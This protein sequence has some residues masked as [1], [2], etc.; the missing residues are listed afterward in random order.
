MNFKLCLVHQVQLQRWQRKTDTYRTW[1]YTEKS[2]LSLFRTSKVSFYPPSRQATEPA[3]KPLEMI[4]LKDGLPFCP[5]SSDRS[6]TQEGC[7]SPGPTSP[8]SS[9][10]FNQ[11]SMQATVYDSGPAKVNFEGLRPVWCLS[12]ISS[13]S[14]FYEHYSPQ[15]FLEPTRYFQTFKKPFTFIYF[16]FNGGK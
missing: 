13:L 7:P 6:L 15:S 8:H 14:I 9:T 1:Y 12:A 3:A 16:L 2:S 4:F 11:C 10:N 5:L